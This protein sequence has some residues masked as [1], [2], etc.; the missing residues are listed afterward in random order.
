LPNATVFCTVV[1]IITLKTILNEK[2]GY[3][4]CQVILLLWL[5][6]LCFSLTELQ[7]SEHLVQNALYFNR[8]R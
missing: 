8:R 2:V 4:F 5:R 3:H 1:V 7:N 6:L